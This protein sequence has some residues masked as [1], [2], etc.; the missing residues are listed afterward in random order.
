MSIVAEATDIIDTVA[1][2]CSRT[3]SGGTNIDGICTM[4]NGRNTTLQIL[5]R[6]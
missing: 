3:I 6:G 4:I 1:C 5:R 2:C